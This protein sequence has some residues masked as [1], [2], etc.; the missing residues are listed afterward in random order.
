MKKELVDNDDLTFI[1]DLCSH[2]PPEEIQKAKE[3][4]AQHIQIA[5][6]IIERESGKFDNKSGTDTINQE[7]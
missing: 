1:D 5:M 7:N 2:L 4:F 3:R 6:R